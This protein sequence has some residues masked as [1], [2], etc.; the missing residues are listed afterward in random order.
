MGLTPLVHYYDFILT[1]F[2]KAK[3]LSLQKCTKIMQKRNGL[4]H[5]YL[6]KHPEG[7]I[8]YKNEFSETLNSSHAI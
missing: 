8:R 1:P 2:N 6:D 3:Q 7:L 4:Y 5:I